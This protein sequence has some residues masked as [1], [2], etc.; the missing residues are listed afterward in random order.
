MSDLRTAIED[1]ALDVIIEDMRRGIELL[2]LETF[3]QP[4]VAIRLLSEN[5]GRT[6]SEVRRALERYLAKYKFSSVQVNLPEDVAKR[7]IALGH[8]IP[9]EDL[10]ED[11]R[12]NEPH[13]TVKYGLHTTDHRDVSDVLADEP[14]IKATLGRTSLFE[15]EDADVVKIEVQSECL[16]KMNALVNKYLEH[17]DTHPGYHPHVTVAY[18]K[19]GLGERYANRTNLEGTDLG[20]DRVLFSSRDGVKTEIQL[21]GEVDP[22]LK[23][24]RAD[25]PI[26]RAADKH[27]RALYL[28]MQRAFRSGKDALSRETLEGALLGVGLR[29]AEFN[30]SQERDERGRWTSGDFHVVPQS[31]I[32]KYDPNGKY[33]LYHFTYPE[34]MDTIL[35]L[36]VGETEN[37]DPSAGTLSLKPEGSSSWTR[38]PHYSVRGDRSA[39]RLTLD[40]K[41]T[42]GPTTPI[43]AVLAKDMQGDVLVPGT[44]EHEEQ[45]KG[46]VSP[47]KISEIAVSNAVFQDW[48]KTLETFRGYAK[49]MKSESSRKS[50]ADRAMF[51]EKL[52]NDPRLKVGL[53]IRSEYGDSKKGWRAKSFR[54]LEFNEAQPRDEKGKW[55]I[56]PG[57]P[58]V[59]EQAAAFYDRRRESKGRATVEHLRKVYQTTDE[60]ETTRFVLPDGTRISPWRKT[61]NADYDRLSRQGML[62]ESHASMTNGTMELAALIST[63]PVIRYGAGQTGTDGSIEVGQQ[64]SEKQAEIIADD[65]SRIGEVLIDISN[66]HGQ[67]TTSIK[68]PANAKAIRGAIRQA[69]L[70]PG[71]PQT[72]FDFFRL[73]EFNPE[74][75][76]DER[77][78]WTDTVGSYESELRARA[79]QEKQVDEVQD[80]L[81]AIIKGEWRSGKR[82]SVHVDSHPVTI[83]AAQQMVPILQEM[84][85]AG[86]RMPEQI[87]VD[88]RYIDGVSGSVYDNKRLS[89]GFPHEVPVTAKPDDLAKVAFSGT[90]SAYDTTTD[91]FVGTTF[92]DLVVH[93]MGH[94]QDRTNTRH[95]SDDSVLKKVSA[96]FSTKTDIA[97]VDTFKRIAFRVSNY[98]RENPTEFVA[99]TFTRLYRGEKLHD[100][101]IKMY[102]ALNGPEIR[103]RK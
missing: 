67:V 47:D 23:A 74:Q 22:S 94:I 60:W 44:H 56:G 49:T 66:K 51:F 38:D 18:V 12:E 91:S 17:T 68:V 93:E 79:R 77:G 99:E 65:F 73:N 14:P 63:Q 98:A 10:A 88:R 32:R 45:V 7:V 92:K 28:L 96:V 59:S 30:P 55:V 11:G 39:V 80:T 21:N 85:N 53:T 26:H 89:V 36:G 25:R 5:V 86:Y 19:K 71:A 95:W 35:S 84:K 64:I 9:D 37:Y 57:A 48:K 81:K 82:T 52:L 83:K 75:A 87:V 76:R 58:P 102:K 29:A 103:K 4:D 62:R 24:A 100:D 13:I 20:F 54:D 34:A 2:S 6:E 27:E 16:H 78:R 50:Y 1:A 8:E 15:L 72:K 43:T 97:G 41:S 3:E 101:V 69:L 70:N 40:D 61:G 42:V 46:V 90:T 31:A 33:P